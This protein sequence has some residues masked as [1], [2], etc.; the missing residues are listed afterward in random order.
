MTENKIYL[1]VDR[2]KRQPQNDGYV[3]ILSYG[4]PQLGDK[5]VTILTVEVVH[6][7]KAAKCW[8]KQMLIERPWETR[9]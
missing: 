9:N 7:M 3:A 4:S 2:K 1:S 8:Y 5:N 6:N